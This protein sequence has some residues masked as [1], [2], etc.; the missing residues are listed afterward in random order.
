M[1]VLSIGEC[2]KFGWE[3]FKRRPWILIGGFLITVL[4]PSIPSMLFPTPEVLPGELPPPT[5]APELLASLAG[6]VIGVFATLGAATFA[7][8]AHDD[9][10]GVQLGDLWNPGPFW[11]FLGAEILAAIACFIGFLLLVVP[12]IILAVGLCFV[13]YVVIERG[14]WPIEALKESWGI[15]KGHKWQLFLLGLALL[16]INLLGLMALVVGVFVTIPI[17]WLAVAHAY[18]TLAAHSG[19]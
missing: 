13:P 4:V 3:T 16:G 8:R 19:P 17:S 7:L 15:T 2:I 14:K 18:R 5:T 9:I 6:L 12:G 10:A 11:R 1:P